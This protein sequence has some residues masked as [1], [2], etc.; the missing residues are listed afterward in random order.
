[1]ARMPCNRSHVRPSSKSY[2]SAN[3]TRLDHRSS[4]DPLRTPARS[5]IRNRP[6]RCQS[7]T[8]VSGSLCDWYYVHKSS[9]ARIGRNSNQAK[10]T[11]VCQFNW[12]RPQC[13][14]SPTWEVIVRAGPV[15][16]DRPFCESWRFSNETSLPM[17]WARWSTI[18][19]AP[20]G[21][22]LMSRSCEVFLE[23]SYNY[24][25]APYLNANTDHQY[26]TLT[27]H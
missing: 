13:R 16:C 24:I 23:P 14:S 8:S 9:Q 2:P 3:A 15:T 6:A 17:A 18:R 11:P 27:Y 1:M 22:C 7:A 5:S 20:S 21:C 19:C 10:H 26:W 12:L 25:G 4:N